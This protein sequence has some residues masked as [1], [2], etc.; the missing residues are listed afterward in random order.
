M[1]RPSNFVWPGVRRRECGEAVGAPN[2][3]CPLTSSIQDVHNGFGAAP[4][5]GWQVNFG[6]G[7][8][9]VHAG[10]CLMQLQSFVV[11]SL[12]T[13]IVHYATERVVKADSS[14]DAVQAHATLQGRAIRLTPSGAE[15]LIP[16]TW[17]VWHGKYKNN[18]HLSKKALLQVKDGKGEWDTEYAEVV[19][20]VL[21]FSKCAAHA[22]EEGWGKE[23]VSFG[24]LQ[25]RAY[26]VEM[27]PEEVA[28]KCS[29]DGVRRASEFSKNVATNSSRDGEWHRS[30]VSYSLFYGDYGGTAKVDMY[31]KAVGKQTVVL[32]FMDSTDNE[33]SRQE[34]LKS[35]TWRSAK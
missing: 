28:A 14:A 20:A 32:V 29:K 16:K 19:N 11:L 4:G 27:S 15:F 31:A 35:F 10:R 25:M 3:K 30:T 18:I 22:G 24:D 23:G 12:M 21:P 17:L 33:E 7:G 5:E 1:N 34:I 8:E 13:A 26:L 6:Q 2:A 9:Q